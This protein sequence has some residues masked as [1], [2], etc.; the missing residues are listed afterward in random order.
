MAKR[1]RTQKTFELNGID[2][3]TVPKSEDWQTVFQREVGSVGDGNY[4]AITASFSPDG[5]P[6]VKTARLSPR[7][8]GRM[9]HATLPLAQWLDLT[10]ID[11][12]NPGQLVI[13]VLSACRKHVESKRR[14]SV[15][16]VPAG[17][18]KRLRERGYTQE[19]IAEIASAY[20]S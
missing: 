5:K 6:F 20:P 12:D 15:V 10:V 17:Y 18:L 4:A 14:E 13:D 7:F 1:K 11:P 9:Q 16:S 3:L 8:G 19:Q 2:R